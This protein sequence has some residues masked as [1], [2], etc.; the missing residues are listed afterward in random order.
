MNKEKIE[1][2]VKEAFS[3]YEDWIVEVQPGLFRVGDEKNG[4]MYTG[5]G[6]VSDLMKAMKEVGENYNYEEK[7]KPDSDTLFGQS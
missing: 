6:G 4:Y 5:R 3:S 1:K 7:S 2:V